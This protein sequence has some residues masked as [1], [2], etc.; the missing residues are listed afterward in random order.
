MIAIS[1]SVQVNRLERFHKILRQLELLSVRPSFLIAGA[2]S[3]FANDR[4]DL[5]LVF[6]VLSGDMLEAITSTDS[7]PK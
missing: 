1:K 6:L 2:T 5:I 4:P 3:L 7:I